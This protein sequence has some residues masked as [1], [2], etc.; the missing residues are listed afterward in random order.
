MSSRIIDD[1]FEGEPAED[2]WDLPDDVLAET[3]ADDD[4]LADAADA[5][6]DEAIDGETEFSTRHARRARRGAA[7]KEGATAGDPDNRT[8]SW[9]V[10]EMRREQRELDNFLK[11]VYEE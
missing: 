4:E 7:T 10:I 2:L 11:E 6:Y 5:P 9:R 1:E 3:G 8:P